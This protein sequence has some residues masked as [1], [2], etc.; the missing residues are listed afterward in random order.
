MWNIGDRVT[1]LVYM[2]DHTWVKKGD[3]CL[4]FSPLYHGT[5]TNVQMT[6]EV[7]VLWDGGLEKTYLNHGVSKEVNHLSNKEL[8]EF[9]EKHKPPQSWY[10]EDVKK[11]F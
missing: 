3:S 5:V 10:D 6:N 1:R 2:D 9:A 7:L 8:L 11:P 4:K